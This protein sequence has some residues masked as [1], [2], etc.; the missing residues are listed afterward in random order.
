MIEFRVHLR[1]NWNLCICYVQT[2]SQKLKLRRRNCLRST[3]IIVRR[4]TC[5]FL[6]D[7]L[8]FTWLSSFFQP[9]KA[10][11]N[12]LS[13]LDKTFSEKV[14]HAEQ[15]VRRVKQ[16]HLE[17]IFTSACSIGTVSSSDNPNFLSSRF[18]CWF[19]ISISLL[20]LCRMTSHLSSFASLLARFLSVALMMILTLM[21]DA[22][23]D[24]S[25]NIDKRKL[26]ILSWYFLFFFTWRA[27]AV[28]IFL[29]YFSSSLY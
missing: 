1:I 28:Y 27:L 16:V 8:L 5:Q 23:N 9:G 18:Q 15:S 19:H 29:L 7:G 10:Q 6:C 11:I 2:C 20:H 13:E 3:N 14:T 21:S 26:F 12:T 24:N 17:H 4:M 22:A 25:Y